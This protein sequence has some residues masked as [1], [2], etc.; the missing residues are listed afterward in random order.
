[1]SQKFGLEEPMLEAVFDDRKAREWVDEAEARESYRSGIKRPH[2]RAELAR[3]WKVGFWTL[4]NFRRGR[5]KDLRGT[6]RD[7]IRAGVIR[8]I[9]QEISRLTHD[10][11]LARRSGARLSDNEIF[12]I[13]AALE[14]ARSLMNGGAK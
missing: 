6:M 5:L 8:E 1:M 3:R 10:L 4:T 13:S 12:E 14:T 2:A 7:R 11:E 9:E